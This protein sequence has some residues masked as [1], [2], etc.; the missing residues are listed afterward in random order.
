MIE[1][2]KFNYQSVF[3]EIVDSVFITDGNSAKIMDV[4]KSGCHLL[5][6][7][8]EEILGQYLFNF[9]EDDLIAEIPKS[10]SEIKMFG[11]VLSN[12]KIRAKSGKVIPVDMTLNTFTDETGNYVM[13]TL[14]DV[15]ERVSYENKIIE[16]NEELSKSNASKDKFFSIIA[17]DLKNPIS[18]IISISEIVTNKNEEVP[19]EELNEFTGM[20][21]NLSEHTYE[22]LENLLSWSRIQTNK[23]EVSKR[24][25]NLSEQINKII[26]VLSPAASLKNISIENNVDAEEIIFADPEMI[27]TVIRNFVS[28][29]IKFSLNNSVIS[30]SSKTDD[31]N[32]NIFVTDKG[33]GM[34]ESYIKDL[35][36]IDVHTSR[37]GTNKEKGTGLGLVLCNEFVKL[38]NGSIKVISELNKGTEFTIQ[39]PKESL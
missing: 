7:N 34:E 27:N 22:L 25:Y 18:A 23:I 8:K 21:K 1:E 5:G 9:I 26:K 15:S 39:L 11:S 10:P 16:I 17:H 29:S 30:I 3:N 37:Y 13:T 12:K 2:N 20:I 31:K 28:N 33:I 38:H 35:F 19:E 6:Y 32:W 36:K 4:N 14:R 24:N